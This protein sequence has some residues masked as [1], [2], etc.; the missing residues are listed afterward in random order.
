[1]DPIVVLSAGGSADPEDIIEK[2]IEYINTM[3]TKL[4]VHPPSNII[5]E[6]KKEMLLCHEI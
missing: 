2:T 6:D 1:M 4:S 5:D 3:G